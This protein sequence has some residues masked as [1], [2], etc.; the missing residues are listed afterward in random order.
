MLPRY[1]SDATTGMTRNSSA[2]GPVSHS[3]AKPMSRVQIA[4]KTSNGSLPR[5]A[6]KIAAGGGYVNASGVAMGRVYGS[7]RL[8][9]Q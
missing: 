6:K 7:A 1:R 4:W 2:H 8:T 9:A 5:A 3:S